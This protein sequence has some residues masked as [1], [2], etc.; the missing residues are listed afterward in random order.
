MSEVCASSL[1]VRGHELLELEAVIETGPGY[2]VIEK[3]D[4]AGRLAASS[5]PRA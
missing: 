2:V 3:T 4:A 1:S 5:D